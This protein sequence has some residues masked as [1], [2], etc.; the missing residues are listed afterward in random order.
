MALF[1]E[2]NALETESDVEQKFIY[3]FLTSNPPLGLGIHDTEI[4]TKKI[5]RQCL[6]GKGQTKKYYYPDYLISIRGVPVIVIEAKNP[7]EELEDG[8]T[9]ARLYANEINANFPHT[10]NICQ[11][12]IA[13]SGKKTIIGYADSA[14]PK[15]ELLF[16]DFNIENIKL[17]ELIKLCNRQNLEAIVNQ[18]YLKARGGAVF[19]T[20]VSQLGGKRVQNEELVENSFGRTL[21][22]E[23]RQ[24][25]DPQSEEDLKEIVNN[26]YIPSKKREQHI[27]PLYKEIRRYEPMSKKN[28]IPISTENPTELIDKFEERVKNKNKLYSM[29]LIVGNVGSG[30]TTFIRYFKSSFLEVN[31]PELASKCAWNFINMNM[32]PLNSD[33][34]YDWVRKSVIL[35]IRQEYKGVNFDKKETIEHL[36]RHEIQQFEDGLGQ[37]I[38][39]NE[40]LY[41]TEIYKLLH[42]Y[43][44]DQDKFLKAII[45]YIKEISGRIPIVVLDNCDK[46]NSEQQLLMFEVAQWLRTEFECLVI[47]PMRNITYDTYKDQPPLDTVV[48]DLIFRIDPPDLL[49]VL[50]ARLDYIFREQKKEN[51][52]Y[53]VGDGI[54]VEIKQEELVEYFKGL[55]YAIRSNS[56]IRSIFYLLSER[57]TRK[58]IQLFADFCKSGH[59]DT[60]EIFKLRTVNNGECN[61]PFQMLMNSLLRK[62]RK[63]YNGEESNFINLFYSNYEDDFPDPFVRIDI[64]RWLENNRNAAKIGTEPLTFRKLI[65]SMELIGHAHEIIKRELFKLVQ[66]KL[67]N[68]ESY[69]SEIQ[70]QDTLKITSSG[71]LHLSLL[72][73]ISYLAACSE[74]VIY[75]NSD[76][77]TSL[78]RKLSITDYLANFYIFS[79]A[80]DLLYYL[81]KY[82]QEFIFGSKSYLNDDNANEVFDLQECEEII[83]NWRKEKAYYNQIYDLVLKYP[84][85]LVED[86][87]ITR[88]ISI[89]L[90]GEIGIDRIKGF[91]PIDRVKYKVGQDKLENG[92]IIKCKISYYD[93][94]YKCF[95]LDYMSLADI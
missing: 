95:N 30:K 60:N 73:N 24:I 86:F 38:K 27:E 6:I 79:N 81:K 7:N 71:K 32:A 82:R 76:I 90:L 89:G 51:R 22:F 41:K 84:T 16:D 83:E 75:K 20:P 11:I 17:V 43:I 1:C 12:V 48:K 39:D 35:Q 26:V 70:M 63:Y 59:M 55:M 23:N 29:L 31:H 18:P 65:E 40:V 88:K 85:G 52:Y 47:L 8:F 61:I 74:D 67:I 58:G 57:N 28:S 2:R 4:L 62:N 87:K 78:T 91:L 5:L 54:K 42:N 50:Q 68:A 53:Y 9:E 25:F 93:N 14:E 49:K 44:E 77:V 10:I 94:Y 56:W 19:I 34:I 46:R 37:F 64:L 3:P 36:F 21:I 72:K 15:F 80:F 33:E 92:N 45:N 13:S 66:E 69:T